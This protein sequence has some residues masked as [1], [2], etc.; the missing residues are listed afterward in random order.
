MSKFLAEELKTL[1][2]YTPGEQPTDK[3]YIKLNTNE[4]PFPPSQ[5]AEKAVNDAVLNS[6]RLYSDP[7]ASKL[8]EAIA[9]FYGVQSKNVLAT[10]GS[11][12]ALAFAFRA[13][14]GKNKGIVFP[15]ITYGFYPVL[16][17]LMGIEYEEIALDGDFGIK[18]DD[19]LQSKKNVIIANPNAQ[20]G[21]FLAVNDIEKIVRSDRDR[22]VVVDEAYVDFGGESAVCLT[23]KY[24]NV[25]VVGTFSKSRN[26]AGLRVGFCIAD[27]KLIKDINTVKYSF[28]PYNVSAL[29]QLMAQ[30]S[31]RDADYF[32]ECTRQIV[33]NRE[34]LTKELKKREFVVLPSLAN[35]VLT[36]S[37]TLGGKELYSK[38]KE[39]GVL[40]R[41]LGNKRIKD[42][43]RITIG[44]TEEI[45]SLLDAVDKIVEEIK[46][47]KK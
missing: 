33:K 35:F 4:S 13:F 5:K 42:Y 16:C 39:R 26:L 25:A 7:T 20:T 19:Y 18:I 24:D 12:E 17:N 23:K 3:K 47:E 44:N 10:N 22:V 29:G 1:V 40:V 43:V 14:C 37:N 34:Y 38:L 46:S 27:E 8:H 45:A 32:K 31:V 11:D 21:K 36:K 41:Y 30:V 28:N 9:E 15:D 2:S 6:L